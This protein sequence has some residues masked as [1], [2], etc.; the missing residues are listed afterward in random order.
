MS[1]LAKNS[2]ILVERAQEQIK[3]N[4]NPY[5]F[6]CIA[7]LVIVF[8]IPLSI[9]FSRPDTEPWSHRCFS[10]VHGDNTVEGCVDALSNGF[11]GIEA[12][13]HL[14][15]GSLYMKHDAEQESNQTLR[16]LFVA[17]D[18]SPYEIYIDMKTKE[19]EQG[20]A[21]LLLDLL[22][23]F[24]MLQKSWVG[25]YEVDLIKTLRRFGIKTVLRGRTRGVSGQSTAVAQWWAGT[26]WYSVTLAHTFVF[27][28]NS[29]CQYAE[30]TWGRPS[31]VFVDFTSPQVRDCDAGT[32]VGIVSYTLW[33]LF[34]VFLFG[35]CA[36][37]TTHRLVRLKHL[38]R[39]R[40]KRSLRSEE[41]FGEELEED[42]EGERASSV[43][44]S[45]A[46]L[47]HDEM[48][49]T[50]EQDCSASVVSYGLPGTPSD[51]NVV[52]SPCPEQ[53]TESFA[54]DY[55]T[56]RA[57]TGDEE[58]AN[59]V[60]TEVDPDAI[61]EPAPSNAR[62]IVVSDSDNTAETDANAKAHALEAT[63]AAPPEMEEIEDTSLQQ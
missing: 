29:P 22:L 45:T 60:S 13:F 31:V 44:V 54:S 6:S 27:T 3:R 58:N 40:R 28:A 41:D 52:E 61:A 30:L 9:T 35:T 17:L 42:P 39:E 49:I 51:A 38:T 21:F 2:V 12:D 4:L 14:E 33:C 19:P 16:D 62:I 32:G 25:V 5:I 46:D 43:I 15:N 26:P 59:V 8:V 57:D 53:A 36:L 11:L 18:G 50:S 48:A 55:I 56:V 37:C 47:V 24:K 63:N 10:D 34:A 20:F 23:E 7:C 1:D